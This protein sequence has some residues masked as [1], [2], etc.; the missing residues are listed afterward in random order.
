MVNKCDSLPC[1][2]GGT[3]IQNGTKHTCVCADGY[4]GTDCQVSEL[5]SNI[6]ECMLIYDII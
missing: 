1:I 6:L 5:F 3:C 4:T 2:H